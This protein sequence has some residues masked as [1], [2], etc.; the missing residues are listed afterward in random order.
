LV[1]VDSI[2]NYL[3]ENWYFVAIIILGGFV[4]YLIARNLKLK[5]M[6]PK[7]HDQVKANKELAI[8]ELELNPTPIKWFKYYDQ[9]WRVYGEIY[10]VVIEVPKLELKQRITREF[11]REELINYELEHLKKEIKKDGGL[12]LEGDQT[13]SKKTGFAKINM[14]TTN[15]KKAIKDAEVIILTNPVTDYESR[16]SKIAN[17]LEDGQII[18]FNT[19]GYW[20]SLR[21]I[22]HI[23]KEKRE[24]NRGASGEAH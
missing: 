18:N 23:E 14:V 7:Y 19:Y 2:I 22:N 10:K 9:V 8:K 1:D 15:A 11:T 21:V 5:S 4:V 6:K 12:F 20:P 16:I 3:G 13:I 24:K 17:F